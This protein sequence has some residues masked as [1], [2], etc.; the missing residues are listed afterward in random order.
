MAKAGPK[1][2]GGRPE[3]RHARSADVRSALVS[4]AIDALRE[5]GFGGA[6]AREIA[7]RAGC[8]QALVF[9]HFGSVNDLLLAA[10]DE[11]SA[12]RMNAY[13]G[14]LDR[15]RSTAALA[16]SAR[17][18]FIEDLEAGYVR[19]LVEMITG[20]QSVPGLGEQVAERLLPWRDLARDAVR[21]AFGRSA[22]ARLL[23]P[24][25]AAHAL[26]AGF[27]GL[28]LL[29]MLDG[30]RAAALAVIDRAHSV[31]RLLD[32]LAGIR[33]PAGGKNER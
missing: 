7:G 11:V 12:R 21:R 1:S 31:A 4:A 13:R 25:E 2:A 18:I 27:I 24:D 9:Y 19:V 26:V 20:A 16:E 14:M 6:S 5:T 10:L 15:A 3:E 30:D 22:A 28:E 29:A 8:S 17:A 33:F 23:P 32:V